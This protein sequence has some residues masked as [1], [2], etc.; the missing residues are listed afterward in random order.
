MND[1][2][3]S[4]ELAQVEWACQG[5]EKADP[6][7][8]L[9]GCSRGVFSEANF[10]DML[11]RY[12]TGTIELDQLPQVTITWTNAR[13]PYVGLAVHFRPSNDQRDASGRWVM[14]TNY[15]CLAFSELAVRGASYFDLFDKLAREALPKTSADPLMVDLGQHLYVDDIDDDVTTRLAMQVSAA[16]LANKPVCVLKADHVDYVERLHFIDKVASLLPY[17]QRSV[18]SASTWASSTNRNHKLRLFFA[19]A[20]RGKS[21]YLVTWGQP[22]HR[23]V[24]HAFAMEYLALLDRRVLTPAL[25][26]EQTTPA[27]FDRKSVLQVLESSRSLNSRRGRSA[28]KPR[29]MAP[30]G[31]EGSTISPDDPHAR[32]E[33][34]QDTAWAAPAADGA[35]AEVNTAKRVLSERWESDGAAHDRNAETEW[36]VSEGVGSV[37][38]I[39]SSCDYALKH[40]DSD[41]LV[42]GIEE[43]G[44]R[45]R[46]LPLGARNELKTVVA[47]YALLDDRGFTNEAALHEFYKALLVLAFGNPIGYTGYRGVESCLDKP[48]GSKIHKSLAMAMLEVGMGGSARLLLLNSFDQVGFMYAINERPI[49]SYE[50]PA[51]MA[52]P[53]LKAP[54]T[55]IVIDMG[56]K[57][58]WLDAGTAKRQAF[59]EA[60]AKNFLVK[61]LQDQRGANPEQLSD[62]L[63]QVLAFAYEDHLSKHDVR[64]ILDGLLAA[65]SDALAGV[66]LEMVKPQDTPLVKSEVLA[67]RFMYAGLAGDRS[68]R[69]QDLARA[70]VKV[71]PPRPSERSRP[72]TEDYVPE[73]RSQG[74]ALVDV[75]PYLIIGFCILVVGGT[76]AGLLVILH[77]R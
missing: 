43:L 67:H 61:V 56:L 19:N 69:L 7:F 65:P 44:R 10:K 37:A 30:E 66:I 13:Q 39:L 72:Q 32:S 45:Q 24:T 58:L 57:V 40:R 11:S 68:R 16:L 20:D 28:S 6:G 54:Y 31:T 47:D 75:L 53:Q 52:E 15:F 51:L 73:P 33:G 18:L 49:R 34:R 60:M 36:A 70:E 74:V 17:G 2:S 21:D 14:Q 4:S 62:D 46:G 64:A 63:K 59:R 38:E 77:N 5:K 27:G 29:E 3:S 9:L 8:R 55:D 48:P 23:R 26:A 42:Q 71:R 25:L 50:T 1:G 41:M 22:D 76:L 12:S 35:S